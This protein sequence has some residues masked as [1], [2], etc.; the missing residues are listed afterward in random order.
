MAN[1]Q[2]YSCSYEIEKKNQDQPDMMQYGHDFA[3]VAK[4]F[5]AKEKRNNPPIKPTI[6]TFLTKDA[7]WKHAKV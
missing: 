3:R 4:E 5:C 6:G 1:G 2:I 7:G